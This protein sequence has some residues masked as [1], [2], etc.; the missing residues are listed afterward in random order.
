MPHDCGAGNGAQRRDQPG[1]AHAPEPPPRLPQGSKM[2]A[3]VLRMGIARPTIG[4]VA[5]GGK[6]VEVDAVHGFRSTMELPYGNAGKPAAL[7]LRNFHGT[8][9]EIT[10]HAGVTF[11]RCRCCGHS[12]P[13]R[14]T[15]ALPK[16]GA[17]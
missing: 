5:A 16:R 8:K 2:R 12:M 14:A 15:A 7:R 10:C 17:F 3:A 4:M 9:G 6:K 1:E 13:P 11:H